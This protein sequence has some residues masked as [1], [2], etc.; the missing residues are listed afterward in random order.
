[1]SP[2]PCHSDYE[3][4]DRCF[5]NKCAHKYLSTG[6]KVLLFL[7][8]DYCLIFRQT[9]DSWT[10]VAFLWLWSYGANFNEA[11]SQTQHAIHRFTVLVKSCC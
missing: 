1:M 10:V 9:E 3:S 2:K 8:V 6:T 7:P 5:N 4:N 11:K